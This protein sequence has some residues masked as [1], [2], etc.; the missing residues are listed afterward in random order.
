MKSPSAVSKPVGLVT[1]PS[2]PISRPRVYTC[3]RTFA[4][5]SGQDSLRPPEQS[6]NSRREA[7]TF[8]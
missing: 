3:V 1:G 7:R 5:S 4:P 8:E 2:A 6:C